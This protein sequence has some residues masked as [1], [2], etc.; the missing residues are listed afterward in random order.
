MGFLSLDEFE[1]HH[2]YYFMKEAISESGGCVGDVLIYVLTAGGVFI[3]VKD[4][5][6]DEA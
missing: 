2:K 4:T 3:Y 5:D 6:S 1:S